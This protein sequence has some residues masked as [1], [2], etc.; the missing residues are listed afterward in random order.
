MV[1]H[2]PI[3]AKIHPGRPMFSSV[4]VLSDVV[5]GKTFE[6]LLLSY[7]LLWLGTVFTGL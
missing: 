4:P 5:A 1:T 7:I 2:P 6:V 3:G